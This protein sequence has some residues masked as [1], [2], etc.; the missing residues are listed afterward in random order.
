MRPEQ[1]RLAVFSVGQLDFPSVEK[2]ILEAMEKEQD[3]AIFRQ[4]SAI[5]GAN[6]GA[7][8]LERLVAMK[9]V[10]KPFLRSEMDKTLRKMAS[11]VLTKLGTKKIS[12]TQFIKELTEKTT[13]NKAEGDRKRK[14]LKSQ[15]ARAKKERAA[16][17][18]EFRLNLPFEV[19]SSVVLGILS[20]FIVLSTTY[21]LI[22]SFS[23]GGEVEAPVYQGPSKV[24]E[25]DKSLPVGLS[26]EIKGESFQLVGKVIFADPGGQGVL[27]EPKMG[28]KVKYFVHL[29]GDKTFTIGQEF[30]AE[31]R[32]VR[33][34]R[35]TVVAEEV[36]R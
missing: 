2:M 24:H 26:R 22:R 13:K 36:S 25:E 3:P 5:V 16:S 31:I 15:M 19:N 4:L 29:E 21:M 6:P 20:L 27:V 7:A 1:R 35:N 11:E 28:K 17:S 9:S 30:S 33:R 8:L 14:K 23:G 18:G 32:P 12:A 10:I 34:D